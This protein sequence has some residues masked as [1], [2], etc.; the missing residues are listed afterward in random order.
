MIDDLD[1]EVDQ[2]VAEVESEFAE[3]AVVRSE[4]HICNPE[5]AER[6]YEELVRHV[7]RPIRKRLGTVRQPMLR[8]EALRA[9][10]SELF[11]WGSE[12]DDPTT[13]RASWTAA[14]SPEH[15]ADTLKA[16]KRTLDNVK[17]MAHCGALYSHRVADH[18]GPRQESPQ[19]VEGVL[20]VLDVRGGPSF[21]FRTFLEAT[22]V[23]VPVLVVRLWQ[24]VTGRLSPLVWDPTG[25]SGTVREVV[26]R[27]F[28]GIV[29]ST[30]LTPV[31]EHIVKGDIR[32]LGDLY[33]CL[34]KPHRIERPDLVF[35]HAPSRGRPS[36]PELYDRDRERGK[37]FDLCS[38]DRDS[39]IQE[40]VIAAQTALERLAPGGLLSLLVPEYRRRGSTI[41]PDP[42]IADQIL[43]SLEG[44]WSL[45]ERHQV[46]DQEP[47]AQASLGRSRG[48]MV[49]LIL[50]D[51]S[52]SL[53]K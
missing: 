8:L 29:A 38:L 1:R 34:L 50:Q 15:R 40:L 41:T 52:I 45:V 30:D 6:L 48:R 43:N 24:G 31:N 11:E 9:C 4:A 7:P 33:R 13:V 16:V 5:N 3:E 2:L 14:W 53:P 20:R 27:V 49:H 12:P 10:E 42:G 23:E 44:P 26:T 21:G 39:Y 28:E 18:L 35:I 46:I 51:P 47:V 37:T 22:P 25:G 32:Q 19:A 36:Y 17:A